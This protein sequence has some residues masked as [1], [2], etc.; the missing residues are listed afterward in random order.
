MK[1]PL[2]VVQLG[3]SIYAPVGDLTSQKVRF[4]RSNVMGLAVGGRYYEIGAIEAD[5]MR[6]AGLQ[7]GMSLVDL[8]CGSGRLASVL[9]RSLN[10]E[11]T[12]R[13]S[14]RPRSH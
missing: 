13:S 7:D 11:F 2:F 14:P 10:V 9:G 8:G 3:I 1:I 6:Y 5:V 4:F 12:E